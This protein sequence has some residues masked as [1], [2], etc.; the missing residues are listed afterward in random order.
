M[1]GGSVK[2]VV[3]KA[4]LDNMIKQG[5]PIIIHFWASWCEPSKQMDKV[6]SHLSIDFPHAQFL[7]VSISLSLTLSLYLLI[8][9]CLV[10]FFLGLLHSL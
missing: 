1:A 6:L 5:Q 4:D 3:S 9:L 7:R 10:F 8:L 2:D